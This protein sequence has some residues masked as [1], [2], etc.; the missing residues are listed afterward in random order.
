MKDFF[1]KT[2]FGLTILAAVI[3]AVTSFLTAYC[4]PCVGVW[5]DI[6][7]D[8]PKYEEPVTPPAQ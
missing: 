8:L 1:F 7:D 4:P 5:N 2:K 6:T 3:A